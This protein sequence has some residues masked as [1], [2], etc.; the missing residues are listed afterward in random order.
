MVGKRGRGKWFL[1]AEGGDFSWRYTP[2]VL[3]ITPIA[4]FTIFRY[5]YFIWFRRTLC[6]HLISHILYIIYNIILYIIYNKIKRTRYDWRL[7]S[8]CILELEEIKPK[9][10]QQELKETIVIYNKKFSLCHN[11]R[12]SNPYIFATQFLKS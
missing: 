10:R 6:F 3:Y 4:H 9:H 1:I 12:F 2:L 8:G 5:I 7:S 11:T